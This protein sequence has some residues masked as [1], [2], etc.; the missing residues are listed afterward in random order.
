MPLI[1]DE[2]RHTDRKPRTVW[3]WVLVISVFAAIWMLMAVGVS[4]GSRAAGNTPV[5]LV[6][7]PMVGMEQQ[8]ADSGQW[9]VL[10]QNVESYSPDASYNFNDKHTHYILGER[11]YRKLGQPKSAAGFQHRYRQWVAQLGSAQCQA[12]HSRT[13]HPRGGAG[14]T[15]TGPRPQ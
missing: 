1:N 11:A 14:V 12:C 9:S 7:A 6:Q 8:L 13:M 4:R 2:L 5:S 15:A 3:P 10:L